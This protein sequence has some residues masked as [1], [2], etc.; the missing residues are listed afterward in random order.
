M[1]FINN[2]FEL[3]MLPVITRP[4]RVSMINHVLRY[5]LIDHIWISTGMGQTRSFVIPT[6]IT[7]HFSVCLIIENINVV[8]SV[9]QEVEIRTFTDSHKHI[10]KECLNSLKLVITPGNKYSIFDTYY[11]QLFHAY[12]IAFP[13]TKRTVRGKKSTPWMTDKLRECIVK[14]AKMYKL[15]LKGR[16]TRYSY[17]SYRNKLTNL[18][19]KV[20]SLYYVKL[21]LEN[22]GNSRK[23]W[24]ILN[25]VLNRKNKTMLEE[26][27]VNG[28]KLREKNLADYIN[29]FFI[30]AALNI[31]IALPGSLDFRCLAP[32]EISSC[33]LRPANILEIIRLVRKLKNKGNVIFDI[34]PLLLKDNIYI[35]SEHLLIL[36]NLSIEIC[37]FPDPLKTARVTPV[38]KSGELDNVDNY[39]PISSLPVLSKLFERLT[40]NRMLS[41]VYAKNILS[42]SQFGFKKGCDVSQAVVKLT[43]QIIQAYHNKLICACFFLD[44]RKAF[45]TVSHD[46]L[47]LKLDHYGF[48]GQ[49]LEYLKSYFSNRRQYVYFNGFRSTSGSVVCGVPQGSILG[50]ICF[51]L[52]INDLP[53]SVDSDTVLFAD[54]AAFVI[55]SDTFGGLINKINKL[56]ADLTAYLNMNQLIPNSRKSKLMVFKSRSLPPLPDISFYGEAI[57]WVTDFKYLGTTLTSTMNFSKY[58]NNIANKVSQ[59]TGT[60]LNLRTFVPLNIL[61][62][63]YYALVYPHLN[64]SIIVWGSAPESHLRP[65]QVRLNNLLRTILGVTWDGVRPSMNT[66]KIFNVLSFLRLPNIFKLNLFKF[67]KLL[68]DGKL[69]VFWELLMARYVTPHSYSTRRVGFRCPDVSCEVERRG[70]SYQLIML[71]EELPAGVLDLN[72]NLSKRRFKRIL[73]EGQ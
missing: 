64:A 34:D 4:T 45:D 5:S 9:S 44:L 12:N 37:I 71:L 72:F 20:K 36:Y 54:D 22:A 52:F 38:F 6:T 15:F 57:E 8:N 17:T 55:T 69:P 21:F 65:L 63:L 61:V 11:G 56:F 53:S 10:F 40:L 60:I 48:R 28:I 68:L 30:N 3:H 49:C 16:I 50:P 24:E 32:R 42:P 2:M 33:F 39:R 1:F 18:I 13:L 46:L 26:L 41:F 73:L 35:F 43:S 58:I 47:F 51:N 19:R 27:K 29:E 67:L 25:N 7:D 59:V 31:R 14:K 23:T 62:K 66:T 70:L